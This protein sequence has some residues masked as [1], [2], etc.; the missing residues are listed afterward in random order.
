[1]VR[2]VLV[3]LAC[4]LIAMTAVWA[5]WRLFVLWPT[6][7]LIDDAGWQGSSY[8]RET[9]DAVIAPVVRVISE[10]FLVVAAVVA[11]AIAALQRRWSIAIA[12]TVMLAGA[13]LTTQLLKDQLLTRPDFG[14]TLRPVNSLPSGH[15]TAAAAVAAT[16]L[17]IA[18]ARWRGPVALVGAIYAGAT[19]VGTLVLGWH[20]PSDVVAA[21]AVVATWYF[22]IEAARSM[23]LKPL[24][25]GYGEAPAG[26][27]SVWLWFLAGI[28]LI[29]G[30]VG[31]VLTFTQ[32]PGI[33]RPAQVLAY[34]TSAA[35]IAGASA[36]AMAAMLGMRPYHGL[37]A[38]DPE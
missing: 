3:P 31:V 4:A 17:L 36:S 34:A 10:P 1:M 7:Q 33:G 35:G 19:G 20:R 29:I 38:G 25:R 2:G 9:I 8:G 13:N 24:P 28:G 16:A 30:V 12:A 26:N 23:R 21:F 5:S 11:F 6:G 22:L 18:P 14:L 32:V 27:A 15:T 37:A